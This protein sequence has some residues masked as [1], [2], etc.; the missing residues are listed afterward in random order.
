MADSLKDQQN[1]M[2]AVIEQARKA[3]R[4]EGREE[5]I[6]L[7]YQRA[8]ADAQKAVSPLAETKASK[9]DAP[10]APRYTKKQAAEI[11]EKFL[12]EAAPAA[13]GPTDMAHRIK[14]ALNHDI[15]FTTLR[16]GFGLLEEAGVI[17]EVG[18]TRTWRHLGANKEH[19]PKKAE[20]LNGKAASAPG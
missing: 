6:A 7:G 11:V 14:A 1:Q 16:R 9:I 3:G 13:V 8:L 12:R 10:Y 17:V 2:K 18:D 19:G 4:E 15:P 5:G 20:A